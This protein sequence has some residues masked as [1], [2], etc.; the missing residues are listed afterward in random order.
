MELNQDQSLVKQADV[1]AQKQPLLF[2]STNDMPDSHFEVQ[3]SLGEFTGERLFKRKPDLYRIIL[4]AL[5]E[6]MGIRQISRAFHVSTNTIMAVRDRES[7]VIDTEKTKISMNLRKFA[8]L[9]TER[10]IEEV[11]FIDIDKLGVPLGIVID[12][13]QLLDGQATSR[14]EHVPAP[15]ID[16]FNR[17]IDALPVVEGEIVPSIGLGEGKEIQMRVAEPLISPLNAI[18]E[19]EAVPQS[20]SSRVTLT[21]ASTETSDIGTADGTT[22]TTND[23]TITSGK[24]EEFKDDLDKK[25][26]GGGSRFR[27][28]GASRHRSKPGKNFQ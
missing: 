14:I 10:L 25:R 12:K 3:E 27:R 7:S 24:K 19:A 9:A 28:G 26:G 20:E 18:S 23:E 4:S 15:A 2:T 16:D 6:G 8:R 5:A 21:V 11:D 1:E 17:I 13:M 22:G